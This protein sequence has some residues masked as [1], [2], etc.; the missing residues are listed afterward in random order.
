MTKNESCLAPRPNERTVPGQKSF[1]VSP[2]LRGRVGGNSEQER[3][4]NPIQAV[5]AQGWLGCGGSPTRTGRAP[6]PATPGEVSDPRSATLRD[7]GRR[8]CPGHISS[9]IQ[10]L[11][12]W[13]APRSLASSRTHL[14]RA[15]SVC[16]QFVSVHRIVMICP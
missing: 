5:S 4:L 11:P 12:V 13:Q 16:K 7:P 14:A 10:K 1:L 9:P 15:L 8:P 6:R 3:F 2:R